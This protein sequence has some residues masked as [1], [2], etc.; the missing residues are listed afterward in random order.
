MKIRGRSP[1]LHPNYLKQ[2]KGI[3]YIREAEPPFDSL[4]MKEREEIL[5]EG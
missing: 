3:S 5:E 2:G 4:V 1:L